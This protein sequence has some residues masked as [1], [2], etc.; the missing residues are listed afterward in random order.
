MPTGVFSVASNWSD[1]LRIIQFMSRE[2]IQTHASGDYQFLS[3]K[4]IFALC[5]I[6]LKLGRWLVHKDSN[7][8]GFH[9]RLFMFSL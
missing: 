6:R 8:L 5:A 1:E 7:L 9:D 3:I 4:I 2:L